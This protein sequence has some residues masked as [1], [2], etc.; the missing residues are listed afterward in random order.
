MAKRWLKPV[1]LGTVERNTAAIDKAV[2]TLLPVAP[3]AL[4]W[5]SAYKPSAALIKTARDKR[6]PGQV[7]NV[8]FVGSKALA[9]ELAKAGRG[10][11]VSQVVPLPFHA[12]AALVAD[13][14][15]QLT[16]G[17]YAVFDFTS[18]ED[19]IDTRALVEG[20]RRAGLSW[21]AKGELPRWKPSSTTT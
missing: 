1:S 3:D 7:A 6:Y 16:Q 21:L 11:A 17:G 9:D 13:Y 8:S 12:R 18:L 19:C 5:I 20:P 15:Q 2:Q 14:R 4:V 10:V